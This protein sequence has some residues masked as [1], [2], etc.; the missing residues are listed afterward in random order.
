MKVELTN[1]TA[2]CSFLHVA[3]FLELSFNPAKTFTNT[4]I[5]VMEHDLTFVNNQSICNCNAIIHDSTG[6]HQCMAVLT[7]NP[8]DAT[9]VDSGAIYLQLVDVT[10]NG[11]TTFSNVDQIQLYGVEFNIALN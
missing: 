9:Q 10:G 1:N 3:S 7:I 4:S 11:Y 8:F 5:K 2:H 6:Y